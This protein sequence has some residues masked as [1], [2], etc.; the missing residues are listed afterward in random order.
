MNYQ[1]L[2]PDRP[3]LAGNVE[4]IFLLEGYRPEHSRERLV[5]N[6]RMNLV[7]ELD[8]RVRYVFDNE[9]GAPRQECRH[10]WLS[11]VHSRFLTIGETT[12]E[13]RLVAVQFAPGGSMP[14]T[15]RRADDFCDAVVEGTSVFG[16][17]VL[18]LRRELLGLDD[19]AAILARVGQWLTARHDAS[20]ETPRDVQLGL[21]RVLESPGVVRWTEFVEAEVSVSYKHFVELFHKHV[22]PSPKTLQRILR[23]SQVFEGVQGK[24]KVNWA[25]VSQALGYSDQ[26][27][28]IREFREFSGYRPAEFHH[29]S[30]DRLNFFPEEDA[31]PD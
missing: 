1:P 27:H 14:F 10:A 18:S 19:P 20:Y 2:I 3:P 23:F 31:S 16:E 12:P 4:L 25:E 17:S 15:H 9:T 28:F 30:H 7:I 29:E 13:N 22:G 11:G 26:A 21:E 5:P 6:G 8:G 24:Q